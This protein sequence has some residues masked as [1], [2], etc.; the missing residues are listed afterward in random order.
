MT[1]T[2]WTY[3]MPEDRIQEFR[4]LISDLMKDLSGLAARADAVGYNRER[5]WLQHNEDGSAEF[6][7]YLEFDDGVDMT[8]FAQRLSAYESEFTKWWRP[9]YESFGRPKSFGEPLLSWDKGA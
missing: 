1:S 9:R 5:M 2:A 8:T 3:A 4:D 6:I 7:V